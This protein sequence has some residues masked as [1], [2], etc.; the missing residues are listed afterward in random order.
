M[1]ENEADKVMSMI[2]MVEAMGVETFGELTEALHAIAAVDT[3]SADAMGRLA[4]FL[5]SHPEVSTVGEAF[6]HPELGPEARDLVGALGEA[7]TNEELALGRFY[8]ILRQLP[9]DLQIAFLRATSGDLEQARAE[10]PS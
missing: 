1:P 6:D 7:T 5:G 8:R 10:V 4:S 2:P 9:L 3:D